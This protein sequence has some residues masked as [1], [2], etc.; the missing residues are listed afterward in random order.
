MV[1][2]RPQKGSWI[3]RSARG[4]QL[5]LLGAVILAVAAGCG[6]SAERRAAKLQSL[7]ALMQRA[8]PHR[9]AIREFAEHHGRPPA[10]AREA[11][12]DLPAELT[13]W[14]RGDV[15][16]LTWRVNP[17]SWLVREF[18][19]YH[20]DENYPA[21]GVEVVGRWCWYTQD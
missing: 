18:L 5:L 3:G 10:D 15:W 17:G 4:W 1:G 11:G 21:R 2:E 19:S 16:H 20:S 12:V 14:T 8:E 7:A 6:P 13:Y 9:L